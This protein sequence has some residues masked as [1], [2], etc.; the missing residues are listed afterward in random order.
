VRSEKLL[1]LGSLCKGGTS[2]D[3]ASTSAF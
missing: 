2:V 1:H 3:E